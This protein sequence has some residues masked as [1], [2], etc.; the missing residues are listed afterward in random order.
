MSYPT[1]FGTRLDPNIID[2][3]V[4]FSQKISIGTPSYHGRKRT[5]SGIIGYDIMYA[6]QPNYLLAVPTLPC[7][8]CNTTGPKHHR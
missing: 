5:V 3:I 1:R 6:T 2:E 8:F 4:E 7:S